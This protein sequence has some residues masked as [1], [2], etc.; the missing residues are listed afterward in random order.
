VLNND[1][2]RSM[3]IGLRHASSQLAADVGI[4]HL[5]YGICPRLLVD[6]DSGPGRS[7]LAA[8]VAG[9]LALLWLNLPA[10]LCRA[11]VATFERSNPPL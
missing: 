4:S 9:W 10:L 7:R 6:N 5:P 2:G 1:I 3:R 8:P 11:A